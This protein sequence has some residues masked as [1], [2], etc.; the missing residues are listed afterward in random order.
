MKTYTINGLHKITAENKVEATKIG[1]ERYGVVFT[2]AEHKPIKKLSFSERAKKG[3][4]RV[5]RRH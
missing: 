4:I 3:Y 1:E 5:G 2:I